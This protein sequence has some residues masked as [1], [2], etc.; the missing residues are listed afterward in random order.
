VAIRLCMIENIFLHI[1]QRPIRA[2]IRPIHKCS[3]KSFCILS[4]VLHLAPNLT[5]ITDENDNEN[6]DHLPYDSPVLFQEKEKDD[7]HPTDP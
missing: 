4:P 2:T 5:E 3:E 7:G 6:D 1:H